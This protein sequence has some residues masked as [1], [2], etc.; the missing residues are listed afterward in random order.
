MSNL[1]CGKCLKI[2]STI[3]N[4]LKHERNMHSRKKD[5][6]NKKLF[7]KSAI[8][9]HGCLDCGRYFTTN[10]NMNRHKNSAHSETI[11]FDCP[12]CPKNYTTKGNLKLHL[13][14]HHVQQKQ[15]T[16]KSGKKSFFLHT[17]QVYSHFSSILFHS[18][19][20]FSRKSSR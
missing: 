20:K 13:G 2:F 12:K 19:L 18:Y 1:S 15:K 8:R 10:S 6:Q 17:L 14:K 4:K 11:R 16:G 5:R 9:S 3:S 7:Q